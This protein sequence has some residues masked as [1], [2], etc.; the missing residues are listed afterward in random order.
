MK[1]LRTPAPQQQTTI[2]ERLF[3]ALVQGDPEGLLRLLHP[4]VEWTPSAWSG[5]SMYRG[6]EGVHL[7]LSQFGESLEHLDVRVQRSEQED[8]HGAV[9]GIVFDTR[10]QM[11]FAVEVAWSYRLEDGLLRRGRA[12]DTWEE[13]VEEAGLGQPT[14]QEPDLA[15]SAER[16]DR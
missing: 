15:R 6:H 2:I 3:K 8:D 14:A 11:K 10:G 12:H 9:L 5:E 4:H 7:W 16:P 13:A 1:Q